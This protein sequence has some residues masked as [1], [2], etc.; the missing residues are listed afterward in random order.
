PAGPGRPPEYDMGLTDIRMHGLIL[1]VVEFLA[2]ASA[3]SL[4]KKM[5]G[6]GFAFT[7]K[8]KSDRLEF[9]GSWAGEDEE[10]PR[11]PDKK[12]DIIAYGP[13]WFYNVGVSLQA[14]IF[15]ERKPVEFTFALASPAKPFMIT[16]AAGIWGGA[17]SFA[18]TLDTRGLVKLA[19]SIAVGA[20]RA[21][22]IGGAKGR[23]MATVGFLITYDA[24]DT[25][26]GYTFI[27][28]FSGGVKISE[29]IQGHLDLRGPGIGRTALVLADNLLLPRCAHC[30]FRRLQIDVR[31]WNDPFAAPQGAT[32]T[33]PTMSSGGPGRPE[34][35]G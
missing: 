14:A 17:G 2:S 6:S 19:F 7:V 27:V 22:E 9:A 34:A 18:I 15:F 10:N 12:K 16:S 32:P 5:E 24:R 4:D 26:V 23:I 28:T 20:V 13:F 31:I 35:N 1:E 29:A 3:V 25:G 30:H 21:I 8:A 11:Y 33:A